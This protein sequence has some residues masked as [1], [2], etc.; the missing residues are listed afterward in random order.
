MLDTYT[1]RFWKFYTDALAAAS[2]SKD[3]STKVG[4]VVL[5]M[6]HEIR[7]TGWNGAARGSKADEDERYQD[8]A[9][10]LKWVVHAEANAI[11]NA[12]RSGTS[13]LGGVMV[14]THA[15]CLSCANLIVQAGILQVIAPRP[16]PAFAQRWAEDMAMTERLF[17]ECGV[18]LVLV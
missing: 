8:R 4:A 14:V 5:G 1:A 3:P 6:G 10:K 9:Q 11:A 2:H 16:E 7:S 13:L 18:R 12:A 15:P 17:D